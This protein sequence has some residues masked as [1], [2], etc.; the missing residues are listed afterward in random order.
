MKENL[1]HT[2]KDGREDRNINRHYK[3][4]SST[5]E[6]LRSKHIRTLEA[7]AEVVRENESLQQKNAELQHTLDLR[8]ARDDDHENENA[9]KN[10]KAQEELQRQLEKLDFDNQQLAKQTEA[11]IAALAQSKREHEA[12]LSQMRKE[13]YQLAREAGEAKKELEKVQSENESMREEYI[14]LREKAKKAW[15]LEVSNRSNL[16][17]IATLKEEINRLKEEEKKQRDAY[18]ANL[19]EIENEKLNFIQIEKDKNAKDLQKKT[20]TWQKEIVSLNEELQLERQR[21]LQLEDA[22]TKSAQKYLIL[23]NQLNSNSN[24][25]PPRAPTSPRNNEEPAAADELIKLKEQIKILTIKASEDEDII[26]A[27]KRQLLEKD[28]EI[29]KLKNTEKENNENE[30]KKGFGKFIDIKRENQVLRAQIKDLMQTQ[31]KILK[32][33]GGRRVQPGGRRRR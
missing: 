17:E 4:M 16:L 11:S 23:E 6:K 29:E 28:K 19:K 13:K 5:Q 8:N 31:A 2:Q 33:A 1:T 32:G 10:S 20:Q 3:N 14:D 27:L 15:E 30:T 25:S 26:N 24:L 9:N 12:S 21:V 7:L 18:V 22:M